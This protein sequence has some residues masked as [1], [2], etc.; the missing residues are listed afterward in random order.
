M[1]KSTEPEVINNTVA[2]AQEKAS[3]D[4]IHLHR[5]AHRP[6]KKHKSKHNKHHHKIKPLSEQK[7]IQ[8]DIKPMETKPLLE[9]HEEINK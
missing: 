5:K 9:K 3:S 7:S 6:H 1:E 2:Q 8:S 4:H